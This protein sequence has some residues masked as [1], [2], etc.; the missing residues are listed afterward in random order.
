MRIV[1]ALA[2]LLLS[3]ACAADT[4]RDW[5]DRAADPQLNLRQ[6]EYAARQVLMLADS[7]ASILIS[8][9]QGVGSDSGLRRQ[10]AAG[11]LGEIGSPQFEAPLL[12]AAFDKNYFLSEA[13]AAALARV[14][15]RLKDGELYSLLKKGGRDPGTVPGGVTE[16]DDW[17]VLSTGQARH[18]DRI[19]GIVMRGLELK[20]HDSA[21]PMPDPLADCVWEGLLAADRDLRLYSIDLV[22]RTGSSL[23]SEKLAALLYV[24]TEPKLLVRALRAMAEMRP[25]QYH[26]AVRRHVAHS[27]PQVA[28][29]ALAALVAMGYDELL[30]PAAQGERAIGSYVVH[31]STPVRRRAV[32]LLAESKNPGALPFLTQAL[33]DRVGPNRAAAA[34]ALGELGFPGAVGGLSPL[35]G[36]GRPDAREEAAVALAK[37]GVVGVT[38]RMIDDLQGD[39]MPFRRAA[40]E[41]LGRI[42]DVRAAPALEKALGDPDA[43]L[44]CLA[45]DALAKLDR[46]QS[47]PALYRLMT[48]G[49]EAVV[50][51]AARQSLEKIYRDDP[52]DTPS[53]WEA[54]R[55]RNKL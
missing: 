18:R 55:A 3:N 17:L 2:F 4:A 46:K 20:Y 9:L 45:A 21:N 43:E 39:D 7:S 27:D 23:A 12:E 50:V 32:E 36:D 10:V 26:D 1:A 16:G 13:A 5:L 38:A 29:E 8:A 14:Y 35:L 47:G 6:R 30:L 25:P 51:D 22:P 11:L 28:L 42:G 44:A 52:G 49:G 37:L 31:P 19:R 40:A 34:K 48:G 24:E 15:S 53:G 41:A 33:F 54:W